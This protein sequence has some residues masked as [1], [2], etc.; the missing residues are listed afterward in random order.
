MVLLGMSQLWLYA[1]TV[2][3]IIAWGEKAHTEFNI[4]QNMCN[5]EKIKKQ[6]EEK[7]M[8]RNASIGKRK[9]VKQLDLHEQYMMVNTLHVF[10]CH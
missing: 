10:L 3:N 5:E 7:E 8:H 9:N 6:T 2:H 1:F 4:T